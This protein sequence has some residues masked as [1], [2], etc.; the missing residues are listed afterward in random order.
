MREK[1]FENECHDAS[2]LNTK[3]PL[4]QH[5]IGAERNKFNLQITSGDQFV[6]RLGNHTDNR[7]G[8][9]CWKSGNFQQ[10]N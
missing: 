9:V 7:I 4:D 6:M 1:R 2:H 5:Q 3:H 8:L 10:I